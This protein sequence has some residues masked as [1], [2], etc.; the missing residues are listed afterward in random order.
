[1]YVAVYDALGNLPATGHARNAQEPPAQRQA[2]QD[3]YLGI[4]HY[5]Y[6]CYLDL[7][8]SAINRPEDEW[9]LPSWY[10][11]VV[12]TRKSWLNFSGTLLS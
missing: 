6:I 1:M 7:L 3:Q 12:Q 11:R 8:V 10:V 4:A 9:P 2:G 5:R